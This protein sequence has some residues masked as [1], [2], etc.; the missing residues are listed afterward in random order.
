MDV[1]LLNKKFEKAQPIEILIWAI[2]NYFPNLGMTTAFQ[3]SGIV[4]MD[5]IHKIQPELPF[6]F[7]DTGYHFAETLEFRDKLMSHYSYNIITI[8]PELSNTNFEKVFGK[9]AYETNPGQCCLIN[10]IQPQNNFIESTGITNWISGLRRDQGG[11]RSDILPV[12]VDE[13]GNYKIF[14]LA[15]LS[16]K[17]IWN[18]IKTNKLPYH[19]LYNK[20]YSSIGCKPNSCTSPNSIENGE[21]NG[22]WANSEKTE[23]GLHFEQ[24]NGKLQTSPV[25]VRQIVFRKSN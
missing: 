7:I 25:A 9:N 11:K 4:L 10:K 5:I 16:W 23:C 21:R 15:Y 20:G 18:Y 6:V 12:M 22:R 14:P 24:H 2:E 13:T 1:N 19:P 8:K 17:D 3:A